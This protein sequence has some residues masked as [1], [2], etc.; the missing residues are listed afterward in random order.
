MS[1]F[2][3]KTL[4]R[5][6]EGWTQELWASGPN[7]PQ[8]TLEVQIQT[9]LEPGRSVSPLPHHLDPSL[10]GDTPQFP[11]LGFEWRTNWLVKMQALLRP[12]LK[13]SLP[14]HQG[15]N[16]P[17]PSPHPIRKRGK[18]VHLGCDCFDKELKLGNGWYHPQGHG[19]H[20]SKRRCFLESPYGS[21]SLRSD[22]PPRCCCEGT[23][24]ERCRVRT[25]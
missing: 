21:C 20:L 22:Q 8:L 25:L 10:K 4:S 6:W 16:W 1:S 3:N 23:R 15:L 9:L 24:E 13:P 17:V 7:P 12:P 18:A 19:G 5:A 2:P 11:Q 14:L